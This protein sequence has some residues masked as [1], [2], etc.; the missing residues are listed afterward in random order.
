MATIFTSSSIEDSQTAKALELELLRNGHRTKLPIGKPNVGN[1]RAN[2]MQAIR[3]SRALIPVLS[4]SGSYAQNVVSEIGAARVLSDIRGML[5][6]PV[7]LDSHAKVP[8]LV[9]P[10]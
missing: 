8:E 9:A 6:L 7:L 5:I 2:I 4:K 10:K 3:E 1:Q